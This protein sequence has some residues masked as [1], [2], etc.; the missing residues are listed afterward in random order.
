MNSDNPND[1]QDFSIYTALYHLL[2]PESE[3]EATEAPNSEAIEAPNS[4]TTP[5][6]IVSCKEESC[7]LALDV[8]PSA[9]SSNS[10]A[11]QR[12]K[13]RVTDVRA[14]TGF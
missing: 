2:F 8:Q 7:E 4:E 1:Q 10:Q 9:N 5:A 13:S 12:A 14:E 11:A 3:K 6:P